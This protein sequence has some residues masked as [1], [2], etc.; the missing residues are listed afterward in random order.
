MTSFLENALEKRGPFLTELE[1]QQTN[2]YRLFGNEGIFG[3]TIDVYG[4]VAIFQL[5]DG[6]HCLSQ[7]DLTQIA[8]WGEQK[9]IFQSVYL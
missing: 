9:G 8:Q 5:F 4:P 7:S 3:L 2:A 6:Q 1:G